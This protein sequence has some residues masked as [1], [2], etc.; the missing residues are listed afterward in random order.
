MLFSIVKD[1]DISAN[2]LNHDLEVLNKWVHQWKLKFI[3]DPLK[4][5]T[6]VLFS[7][8][9][10]VQIIAKLFSMKLLLQ[11]WKNRNIRF[12]YLI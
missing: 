11:K 5:A 4:Q 6:E 12:S 1:T 3:P 8:K 7:C 9:N 10:N 2:D